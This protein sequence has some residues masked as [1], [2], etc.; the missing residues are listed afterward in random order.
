VILF[1]G[2]KSIQKEL[3]PVE[4]VALPLFRQAQNFPLN[5]KENLY[6]QSGTQAMKEGCLKAQISVLFAKI[7]D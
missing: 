2:R 6:F 3:E 5:A 1:L 7:M 4:K